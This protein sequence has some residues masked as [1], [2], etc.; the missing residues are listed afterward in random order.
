MLM[1]RVDQIL[2]EKLFKQK[3]CGMAFKGFLVPMVGL[4]RHGI[5]RVFVLSLSQAA[6]F[7]LSVINKY[8]QLIICLTAF[9]YEYVSVNIVKYL[10]MI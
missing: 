7:F 9:I 5:L 3:S 6:Y 8:F 1:K 4:I 2:G 10:I